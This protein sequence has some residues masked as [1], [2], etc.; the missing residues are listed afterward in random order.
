MAKVKLIKMVS[1]RALAVFPSVEK[2]EVYEGK[3]QDKRVISFVQEDGKLDKKIIS[4]CEEAWEAIKDNPESFGVK[5]KAL[6]QVLAD[7]E[8]FDKPQMPWKENKDGDTQFKATCNHLDTRTDEPRKVP[9]FDGRAKP[10]AAIV[11]HGS[12]VKVEFAIQPYVVSDRVYGVKLRMDT[13]QLIKQGDGVGGS[14]PYDVE[15]DAEELDD[16]AAA[17]NAYSDEDSELA[18][19]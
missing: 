12:T 2:E 17:G 19:Y 13:V 16:S 1:G 18:D 11:T 3:G 4:A 7:P 5:G 8:D 14:N 9:V 10:T 6:K 15:D